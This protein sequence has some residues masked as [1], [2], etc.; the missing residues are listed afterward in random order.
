MALGRVYDRRMDV[1]TLDTTE[2]FVRTAAAWISAAITKAQHNG[3]TITIG[4]SGGSTP[5]PIYVLLSTELG[6]DW[7]RVT[8]FLVDER[9]VPSDHADSNAKMLNETLLTHEA[10]NAHCILP[11]TT[12]PLP[13]CIQE[14][15]AKIAKLKPE[16]VILG[17]G[18]DGH[19]ASLFPP[20]G[21]QAYGPQSV[22]HTTTDRFAVHDRISVTFPVLLKA[23]QRLF[24]VTGEKKAALLKTMQKDNEDVSMYPAQYLFDERTTWMVGV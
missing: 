3:G 20:V 7:K 10:A 4:L 21:P 11:D 18:D 8:F 16:M 13:E 23:E 17:M 6:I 15:E 2:Q 12:L 5:K 14:Y 22:I 19:I 24:L 9:Y 1:I